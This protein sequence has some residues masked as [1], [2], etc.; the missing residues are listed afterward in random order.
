MGLNV[1]ELLVFINQAIY[2]YA[3]FPLL[4]ENYRIKSAQ[5]LSNGLLFMMFNSY[6][7]LGLYF[8]SLE[9]PFSYRLSALVQLFM[10]GGLL[11]QH[12]WYD[13]FA[14]KF[15]IGVLYLINIAAVISCIPLAVRW[16]L[17]VGNI[18]GWIGLAFVIL[19]RI[20]QIIKIHQ[21]RSV[22][23]FSYGYAFFLGI[24]AL[25]EMSIVI[26][27][28]LPIQTLGTSSFAFLSFLIFTAQFYFFSWRKK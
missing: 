21:E 25:M 22:V 9:T 1:C 6:L 11:I 18:A 26:Y 27:Y 16:P 14:H 10:T 13:K 8:F 7:A 23:G 20:P 3:F 4:K 12:F 24:A 15:F 17:I 2:C 28:S 5:G 19:C